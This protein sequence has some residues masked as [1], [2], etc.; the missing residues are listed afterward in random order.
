MIKRFGTRKGSVLC[1][2]GL[3]LS[4]AMALN[5]QT[6]R[7]DTIRV[8]Y[9]GGQSNMDGFGYNRELPD[10]LKGV[11]EKAWVFHG[12]PAGDNLPGGG[13]GFWDKLQPGHGIGFQSDGKIN[14]LSDRFG[15]EL[16]LAGK[17]LELFPGE[18]L[19]LIKYSR[20]GTSIDSMAAGTFGCWEPDYQGSTGIN[21]YDHFLQTVRTAM[22][23]SDINGDGIRDVLVPSGIIWMQG[24]SDASF[25]EEVAGR[26]YTNLKR[27]MD[28]IRASFHCD[29]L[30]VVIGKISDSWEDPSDGKVWDHCEL[31]QYAQEKFAR[32]DGYAAIVRTTRYYHYSDPWHYDSKGY[33]DLGEQ[34]AESIYRLSKNQ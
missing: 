32:S 21:Q 34:F 17:L 29:D 16:S 6:A 28:L 20:G 3:I 30:P 10:S 25:T 22:N 26:Y 19:A 5:A 27:M 15:I 2:A 14:S 4:C 11:F 9:L 8:Y 1:F 31:V 24:E 18:S 23:T 33:L 12:N 7:Y 13:L